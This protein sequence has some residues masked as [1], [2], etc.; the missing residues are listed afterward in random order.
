MFES[1]EGVEGPTTSRY[2][3][4]FSQRGHV[5]S[6]TNIL[7]NILYYRCCQVP[8]RSNEIPNQ[9]ETNFNIN[10]MEVAIPLRRPY[11]LSSVRRGSFRR[12]N[13]ALKAYCLV[14]TDFPV[15]GGPAD[16]VFLR[17]L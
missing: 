13:F 3:D 7:I 11:L 12:D 15:S 5:D 8:S 4:S 16:R 2:Y 17:C 1:P 14:D 6:Q 9:T 10:S